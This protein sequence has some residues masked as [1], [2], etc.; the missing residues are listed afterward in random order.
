[1]H[2]HICIVFLVILK[3]GAHVHNIDAPIVSVGHLSEPQ[4]KIVTEV[5][6][7]IKLHVLNE[8]DKLLMLFF[9]HF[10][11]AISHFDCGIEHL[12]SK[13]FTYIRRTVKT[14]RNST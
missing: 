3:S 10:L 11:G 9:S 13:L 1:M 6:R 7:A 2:K 12:P 4:N 5:F 8:N 14:F